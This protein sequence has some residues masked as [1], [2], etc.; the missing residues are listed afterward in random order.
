M[1]GRRLAVKHFLASRR[2]RVGC[3]HVYGL[4][5]QPFTTAGPDVVREEGPDQLTGLDTRDDYK[6][7]PA[8]TTDRSTSCH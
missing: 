1:C 4:L 3:S 2:L 6:G 7:S 5:V 8:S